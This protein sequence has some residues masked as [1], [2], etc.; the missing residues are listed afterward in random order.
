MNRSVS[1]PIPAC[2]LLAA[3]LLLGSALPLTAQAQVA[4]IQDSTEFAR[5]L[6]YSALPGPQM[7]RQV[8]NPVTVVHERERERERSS[9][10][11]VGAQIAGGVLGAVVGSRFGGGRGS[12]VAT[13]VGAIGGAMA[14]DALASGNGSNYGPVTTTQQQCSTVYEPGPPSGY[15]VTYDYKGKLYTTTLRTPPGEYLRVRSRITVE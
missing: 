12:D 6:N 7:A 11:N 14:G 3:T 15:Q 10:S 2:T 5:V 9:G 4:I 8:C 1:V 13:V